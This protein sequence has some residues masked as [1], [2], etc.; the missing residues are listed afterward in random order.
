VLPTGRNFF[1]VDARALPTHAAWT[2][3]RAS[4]ELLLERHLQDHGD[5]LRTLLLT[6]WGTSC[7][8]TGGDDLAQGLALMGVRPRWEPASGRVSGFEVLPMAH[9][10]R[11]RVDVTLRVSGFFRDAFPQLVALFDSAARAVQALD[12]PADLNPAAGR[13]RAGESPFR[14]YGSKPGATARGS[15][16]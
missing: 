12:E 10:A 7:M 14:V 8:R 3:G 11:P 9:L 2:L 16:R 13:A 6:A 15:R 1:S 5:H 4:A